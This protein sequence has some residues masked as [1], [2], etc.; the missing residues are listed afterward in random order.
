M[1]LIRDRMQAVCQKTPQHTHRLSV[2]PYL[3][4]AKENNEKRSKV[5]FGKGKVCKMASSGLVCKENN[6]WALGE[7]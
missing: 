1:R 3:M 4:Q 5:D 6:T 7:S 2:S